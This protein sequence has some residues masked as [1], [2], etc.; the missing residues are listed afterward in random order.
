MKLDRRVLIRRTL[1]A[2]AA[3]LPIAAAVAASVPN[4]AVAGCQIT[5]RVHNSGSQSFAVDWDESKVKA[6]GGTWDKLAKSSSEQV[7][8]GETKSIVYG[9]L[10]NCG[11]NRRYQ[12][13]TTR[14]GD[15]ETTYFPSPD[16]WTTDQT[17]TI[18]VSM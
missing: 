9:A 2:A 14:G 13:H 8:P 1:I 4:D 10:F 16:G 5:V 3:V 18:N 15:E 7:D 12:I 11:A 17:P 6:R